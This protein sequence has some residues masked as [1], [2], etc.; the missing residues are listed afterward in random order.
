MRFWQR[1][2]AGTTSADSTAADSSAPPENQSEAARRSRGLRAGLLVLTAGIAASALGLSLLWS[3][4]ADAAGRRG[5]ALPRIEG[6]L[7]RGEGTA[8]SDVFRKRNGLVFIYSADDAYAEELAQVVAQIERDSAKRNLG[9]LGVARS[10]NPNA[11]RELAERVGLEF[12]V[13]H[14]RSAKF[15]RSLG[16]PEGR[17]AVLAVDAEG[18]IVT[19]FAT[20]PSAFDGAVADRVLR[21]ALHIPL[22]KSGTPVFGLNPPA[23]DFTVQTLE[24]KELTLDSLEGDVVVV[25]FFLHTCPHCHEMLKFMKTLRKQLGRDDFEVVAISLQ[26]KPGAVNG[27]ISELGLDYPVYLDPD[28]KAQKSYPATLSVPQIFLVDREQRIIASHE[29]SDGRVKALLLMN[30]RK[31]LGLEAPIL[32][33]QQGYSGEE[34]CRIC[35]TSEHETWSLTTH[36]YAFETL[37]EHGADRNEECLACHTVGFREPGGYDPDARQPFLEGVQCENCHGRGGPHQSP[38]FAK[39]GF[40]KACEKCHTPEHSLRFDFAE[41]L[42]L[43]SHAA[44]S[45]FSSLSVEERRAFLEKRDKR[46]RTLFASA[47][48]VGSQKCGEC[49]AKEFERWQGG[50]HASA[51]ETLVAKES[52]SQSECQSC[53]TT[54]FEQPGGFPAGGEALHGVGCE[55]CHG[56]GGS[57]VTE[58]SPTAATIFGLTE[59]CGSCVILQI[60]GSCHDDANDPNFEFEVEDKIDMIRHGFRDREPPTANLK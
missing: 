15:E 54:G 18:Y 17:A 30:I 32:L 21:E 45:Q 58:A 60:C 44:N 33:A 43:I 24:G 38:E 23:P 40:D 5:G 39:Q 35:H 4:A 19:S 46:E 42:P 50:P 59:K 26:N 6:P 37:V 11:S 28:G 16:L 34:A 52:Q 56:P 51:F 3:P 2:P 1:I 29:G 7:L 47:D 9:L 13:V 49:H 12:P 41:R 20:E 53:H 27:M 14:D 57:H 8:S 22:E 10:K 48:F 55:S 25:M 36:A 31:T